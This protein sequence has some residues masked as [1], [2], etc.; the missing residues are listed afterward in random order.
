MNN[1][2]LDLNDFLFA[3]LDKLAD[4]DVRGDDLTEALRRADGVVA[5]ATQIN[6]AHNI[7]LG[8]A[9]LAS[10]I[11]PDYKMPDMLMVGGKGAQ[12]IKTVG[13]K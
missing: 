10:G 3:V 8:A 12:E 6:A 11:N 1:T 4:D 13:K 2:L 9:K 5:V 7:A